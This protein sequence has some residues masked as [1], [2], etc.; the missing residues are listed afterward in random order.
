MYGVV[1]F[2]SLAPFP[3]EKGKRS[4]PAPPPTKKEKKEGL[5]WMTP[6]SFSAFPPPAHRQLASG[7]GRSRGPVP[8]RQRQDVAAPYGVHYTYSPVLRPNNCCPALGK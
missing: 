5:L 8:V 4:G 7:T 2:A 6:Q 1:R 3:S